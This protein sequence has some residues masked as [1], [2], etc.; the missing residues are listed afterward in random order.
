MEPELVD[1]AEQPQEV[2]DNF[3]LMFYDTFLYSKEK[4]DDFIN[5]FNSLL[6]KYQNNPDKYALVILDLSSFF[7]QRCTKEIERET[8]PAL[9]DI[10]KYVYTLYNKDKNIFMK[11]ITCGKRNFLNYMNLLVDLKCSENEAETLSIK[12]KIK[13]V[14][15]EMA[16]FRAIALKGKIQ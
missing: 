7:K 11:C 9:I 2:Y 14:E 15:Q 5:K 4:Y 10:L 16:N 3:Y 6:A 12:E 8:M 13:K 1:F